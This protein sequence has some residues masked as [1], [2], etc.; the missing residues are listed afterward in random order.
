[1]W[2][3]GDEVFADI[4]LPEE[5]AST[6]REF[7]VHPAL[8]DSALHAAAAAGEQGDGARVPFSW[9]RVAL[10]AAGA[11]ALR[12]HLTSA[13]ETL[14]LRAADTEGQLVASVESLAL[15]EVSPKQLAVADDADSLFEVEWV[16]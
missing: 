12:V 15:R 5:A 8:L 4:A 11:T 1:A 7:G 6:A 2:R 14:A 3:R 16:S 9:R 10:Y 13:G